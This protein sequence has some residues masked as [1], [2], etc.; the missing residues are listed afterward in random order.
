MGKHHQPGGPTGLIT[1]QLYDKNRNYHENF[2]TSA[3]PKRLR[4][5]HDAWNRLVKVERVQGR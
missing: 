3:G 4:Y 2:G 1:Q 5:T